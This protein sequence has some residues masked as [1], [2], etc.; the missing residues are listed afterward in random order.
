M[1]YKTY[2][3]AMALIEMERVRVEG[4]QIR[5]KPG[6]KSMTNKPLIRLELRE[7]HIRRAV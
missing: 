7:N 4:S 6:V 2:L 3:P 5:V 1:K